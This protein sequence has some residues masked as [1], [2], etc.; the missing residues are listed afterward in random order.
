[1]LL[2]YSAKNFY[3]FKEGLE[4][5]FKLGKSCPQEISN[6]KDFTNVLCVKGANGA[7]KSNALKVLD[8]LRLFCRD[9]FLL[10]PDAPIGYKTFFNN[11]NPSEFCVEFSV[12]G[13][14]YQYDL[15]ITKNEILSEKLSK[16][17]KRSKTLFTRT[18]NK[19]ETIT[20]FDE[21]KKIK[22]RSNASIISTAHQYEI[23]ELAVVYSFFEKIIPLNTTLPKLIYN[24]NDIIRN[25][26]PFA[27]LHSINQNYYDYPEAFAFTKDIL[28]KFDLGIKD[29]KIK[30]VQIDKDNIEYNPYFVHENNKKEYE[31]PFELES[32]GTRS[33]YNQLFFYYGVLEV[34]GVFVLDEFDVNLHPDILPL[35]IDLFTNKETNPHNAQLLFTTH[36]SEILNTLGKYRTV[37]VNKEANESYLYRLDELP[38]DIIRNDRP[39]EPVYR[40]GKIGGVP[41]V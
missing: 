24:T 16:T 1:M 9:S 12:D 29:I 30:K 19:V 34:G 21:L 27:E 11:T 5:S 3:C 17:V 23:K 6:N 39:L 8:F 28:K 40:S 36:N 22:L 31:L 2:S 4:V 26:Q 37:L 32:S 18:K 35:L 7:G 15:S 25:S 20:E 10:K 38:G 33:L 14:V 13:I 41:K